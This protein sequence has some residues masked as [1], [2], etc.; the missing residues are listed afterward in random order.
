MSHFYKIFWSIVDKNNNTVDN[1]QYKSEKEARRIM[2]TLKKTDPNL[3]LSA[4][5]TQKLIF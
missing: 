5:K 3:N 2:E 4:G 1:I